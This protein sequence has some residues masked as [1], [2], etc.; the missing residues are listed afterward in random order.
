MR[1]R[2]AFCEGDIAHIMAG[3]L[4]APVAVY[5]FVPLFGRRAAKRRQSEDRFGRLAAKPGLGGARLHTGRS[6]RRTVLIKFSLGNVGI[7]S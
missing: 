7:N 6:S 3:V 1:E 5:P 2:G 4:D